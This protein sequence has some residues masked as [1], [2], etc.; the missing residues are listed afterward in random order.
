MSSARRMYTAT[1]TLPVLR[2]TGPVQIDGEKPT[3]GLK[4]LLLSSQRARKPHFLSDRR[5]HYSRRFVPCQAF[6]EGWYNGK[7]N[8][9]LNIST[10]IKWRLKTIA[11][12]TNYWYN[13]S[14]V[15]EK[16]IPRTLFAV[17]PLTDGCR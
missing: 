15:G 9:K 3:K 17:F 11:S 4:N 2:T 6:Y 7:R 10:A 1:S 12:F 16:N 8:L 14:I 5:V 13:L